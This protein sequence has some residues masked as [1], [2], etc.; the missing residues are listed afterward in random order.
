METAGNS[1]EQSAR[2]ALEVGRAEVP[3]LLLRNLHF[4]DGTPT[5]GRKAME[6]AFAELGV[7]VRVVDRTM[8][9]GTQ[10]QWVVLTPAPLS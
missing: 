5:D 9:N 4:R 6:A 7:Q 3:W 1:L 2:K 10:M 8:S